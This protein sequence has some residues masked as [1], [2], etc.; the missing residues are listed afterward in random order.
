MFKDINESYILQNESLNNSFKSAVLKNINESCK[1]LNTK[2][3]LDSFNY[4][5]ITNNNETFLNLFE[6]FL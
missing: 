3:S 4:F 2:F 6:R 1:I 5:P